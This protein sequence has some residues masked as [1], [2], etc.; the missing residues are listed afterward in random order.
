MEKLKYEWLKEEKTLMGKGEKMI[1]SM[2]GGRS[3]IAVRDGP[4][5]WLW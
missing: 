1:L 3:L 5:R 2:E 4:R